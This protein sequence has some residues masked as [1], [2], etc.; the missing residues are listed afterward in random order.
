MRVLTFTTIYNITLLRDYITNDR[1]PKHK[2]SN[3]LPINNNDDV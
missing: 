1:E 2:T 3:K